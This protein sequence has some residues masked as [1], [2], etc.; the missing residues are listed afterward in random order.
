MS[1]WPL[2]AANFL[3]HVSVNHSIVE[4]SNVSS[5]FALISLLRSWIVLV[6]ETYNEEEWLLFYA[7][8]L[9]D[10]KL[11]FHR[12]CDL[13]RVS[14][15]FNFNTFACCHIHLDTFLAYLMCIILSKGS[16]LNVLA[17][18][19]LVS[20]VK[21]GNIFSTFLLHNSTIPHFSNPEITF[22]RQM[23]NTAL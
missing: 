9:V 10:H 23:C 14:K 12:T 1:W 20:S 21:P 11:S 7:D 8:F 22:F 18:V 19:V 13:C 5:S 15:I 2:L 3:L 16:Q 4:N 6:N 17:P